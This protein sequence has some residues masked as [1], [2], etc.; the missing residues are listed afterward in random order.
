M[1]LSWIADPDSD[2]ILYQIPAE[3]HKSISPNIHVCLSFQYC[4]MC[5]SKPNT[6]NINN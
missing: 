3:K 5:M 2:E 4:A 1:H 6:K